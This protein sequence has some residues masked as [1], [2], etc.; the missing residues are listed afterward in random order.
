MLSTTTRVGACFSSAPFSLR[1]AF[2]RSQTSTVEADV[3][4]PTPHPQQVE[5]LTQPERHRMDRHA[6]PLQPACDLSVRPVGR[7]RHG[8]GHSSLWSTGQPPMPHLAAALWLIARVARVPS[9]PQQGRKRHPQ[10]S[11]P[12][13]LRPLL[14][15]ILHY[16]LRRHHPLHSLSFF[17]ESNNGRLGDATAHATWFTK[18]SPCTC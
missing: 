3:L 11:Q 10:R 12:Q 14:D 18:S 4:L 16:P 5:R 9:S 7:S 15:A 8:R 17:N 2:P 13:L 6:C 1:A